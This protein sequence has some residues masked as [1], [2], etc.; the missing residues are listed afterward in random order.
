VTVHVHA[1]C[2][3]SLDGCIGLPGLR[4]LRL[5]GEADLRRVHELRAS[6]DGI[7]VGVGTVLADDPKLTVKWELL[8]RP[9]AKAPLRVVLD[10]R[11]RTP[12][13]GELAKGPP[14]V[15]VHATGARGGP[16]NAERIEVGTDARGRLRLPDVLSALE[17]KG[18]RRLMVEGG[19]AV[20]SSFLTEGLVDELTIYVAPKLVGH[21]DAPRLFSGPGP[22]DVRLRLAETRTLGEGALLRFV[23]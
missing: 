6:S 1:N 2:A 15:L 23:R 19:S 14:L 21:K 5:S 4:P 22:L 3:M 18:I 10:P 9:A 7:L 12:T 17:R 16:A 20:L 13:T 11:L 8:A